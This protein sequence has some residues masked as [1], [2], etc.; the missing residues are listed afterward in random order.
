MPC[1]FIVLAAGLGRRFGGDRHKALVPL[2]GGEGSLQRLL[3][4]LLLLAP[5]ALIHVVVNH[6]ASEVK[7]A[8]RDLSCA[9]TCAGDNQRFSGSP[10]AS[11]VVGLD[12]LARDRPVPGAWVLFADTLYSGQGLERLLASDA[13]RL[14]VASQAPGTTAATDLIG[15]RFDPSSSRLL[16]LGPDEP[17]TQAVMAP[18]V[19]WPRALW[20]TLA[21]AADRGQ[22]LQWQV[23]R[24]HLPAS[25]AWVL[26]LAPGFT[27]DIDTP[28]DLREARRSLV[29]PLAVAL[30]RRTIS[31]EER[32]LGEPDRMEGSG[33][34]KVCQSPE[35][36]AIERSALEWLNSAVGRG[37]PAV[38]AAQGSTL[39]LEP[40]QGIRLYDLLRLLRNIGEQQPERLEQA[41]LASRLLLRRSF[42]QLVLVQRALLRW[43]SAA[44]R[45]AYPLASHTAGL[46][47]IV[48]R[49]LGLPPL[50]PAECRELRLLRTRWQEGDALIPFRDATSKNILVAI[51]GLAPGLGITPA[52][53]LA[54]L[55]A[56]LD[57]GECDSV[58]LVDFDFTS[59]VH[60]TAPED[61]LFSLLAH[62]GTLPITRTLLTELIPGVQPWPN[63]V[64]ELVSRI[65]PGIRPDP[66]RAARALLVRYLRFGGRKLLYRLI[67]PAAFAVRFR[68][69]NPEFYFARLPAALV[70]LD[71]SFAAS[72]PR[73][74]PACASS[75]R[76]SPCCRPG[77][78]ATPTTTCI[79]PGLAWRFPTGRKALWR[80]SRCRS[81]VRAG[82]DG[83]FSPPVRRPGGDAGQAHRAG[84]RP[85][86][87]HCPGPGRADR[88]ADRRPALAPE[89]RGP[90]HGGR[91]RRQGAAC[92]RRGCTD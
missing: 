86:R 47:A 51:D 62:A 8:T 5:D 35:H 80:S 41:R 65:H 50:Q 49:L 59:V 63:A 57:C 36:A 74:W 3:R 88:S 28:D 75:G 16:A 21:A 60:R 9:I 70:Q 44:Q 45:P 11:L 24:E 61:D 26:P 20:D 30:F 15:L 7:A 33:F 32:N 2:L 84:H 53:R 81:Q 85:A 22:A 46:L 69:D 67:N 71:P 1:A 13:Q 18:A 72:F 25:P 42:E 37:V 78:P 17:T 82:D 23:L 19:H 12:S 87:P 48:V 29:A 40:L 76:P 92:R 52:E 54:R 56:W 6:R 77:V 31:K 73:C 10:L 58:R 89:R 90:R 4:Q 27:R 66:E 39:L 83:S 34:R 64:A 14:L 55:L 43:P 79:E 68:Y 38:L 91:H